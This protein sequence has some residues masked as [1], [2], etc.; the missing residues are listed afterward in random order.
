M[1]LS[2]NSDVLFEGKSYHIQT[3]DWGEE[4]A[5]IVSRIF[6]DGAVIRSFKVPYQEAVSTGQTKDKVPVKTAMNEQH[7][8]IIDLLTTGQLFFL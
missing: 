6:V 5:L 7:Q 4:K 1:E 8:K 3:E 2:F